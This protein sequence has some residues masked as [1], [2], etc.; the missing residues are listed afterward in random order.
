MS[1]PTIQYPAWITL[2]TAVHASI[3]KSI[4]QAST[5]SRLLIARLSGGVQVDLDLPVTHPT[6]VL[7]YAKS[8]YDDWEK[9]RLVLSGDAAMCGEHMAVD[10]GLL[11]RG[12]VLENCGMV[13]VGFES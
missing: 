1:A 4:Q 10:F 6:N 9:G 2:N 13:G 3:I 12:Y 7:H 11:F 8:L 5:P